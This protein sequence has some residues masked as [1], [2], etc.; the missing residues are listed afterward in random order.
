[1][2][3]LPSDDYGNFTFSGSLTGYSMGD[4]LLGLANPS[5]FAVTG[6][7][8]DARTV[9]WGG[10]G[11]DTWQVNSHLTVNFGLRWELLPPFQETN[12]D[13][14]TY[15]TNGN[16]LTV[17]VPDKFNKFIANDPLLQQIYTGFLQGVN[18]CSLPG[19]TSLLPCSNIETASQ[20]GIPQGLRYWNWR[21][22]DPRVSVAYRP[23]NDNK[24]V[25]RAGFGI[26]TMTTLGPMSFNSGI[27]ALSD[28]LTYNNSVT[29]G[30][31]A[32]QFPQ[33]SPLGAP[34]TLGGGDFE[35]ANN[36][37]WKDPSSA[38]WNLTVEREVTPNTMVR[39][40]YTG[41]SSYHLP[42][43]IDRN[44][45][46]AST[47]PYT[48]PAN[49]YSVVDPRA[50]FQNWNLLMEAESIG[51]Q[52]YQAGT[53]E[54]TH[55]ATHGLTFQANY[56]FAKNIS[57]AQ[58]TDAPTAYAGEEPYA[59]EIANAYNIKYDRGNVVGMPRQRFLLTGSYQ[60]PFGTGRTWLNSSGRFVNAVLGGWTLSTVTTMQTGQ[61][62]TPT[63]PAAADQSN[64]NLIVRNTGGAIARPD[65]VGNPYA[66]QTSGN[67][68]NINAFAL[69][70][71]NAGRFGTCGV[72]ILQGPGMIDVDGGLAKTFQLGERYRLRFEATFTNA[73]NHTNFAPPALNVGNPASFGVLQ[74]A[75]PQGYGGNRTGQMALRLDF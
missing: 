46:P 49:G 57:D 19:K 43:T 25:I 10:F 3:F 12:G 15:L 73:L 8:M 63:M 36:P 51:N 64:T 32:F 26:Y 14:A 53:V 33:T 31:A 74:T 39:V 38:Q 35:E 68:F 21:D 22:F 11:Q 67:F 40:S 24:T 20:A 47:T 62:L 18:A 34:A 9:Q 2:Y 42:I 65:C 23:F 37:H 41:Q 60:L 7:Q 71:A 69:P 55:R 30:A 5:Y 17:V 4:F 50:P 45:I 13:I 48:I 1:M 44:Q 72:G 58:G 66:N 59:V 6:P 75:L 29:N 16:N 28:L 61:W 56:T 52:S 27:I 54:F 70:P